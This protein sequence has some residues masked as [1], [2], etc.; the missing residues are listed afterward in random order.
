VTEPVSLIRRLRKA[1][2]TIR[3][4]GSRLIVE[5]PAGI[6][7]SELHALLIQQKP[8]LLTT[9]ANE[10]DDGVNGDGEV[11]RD[12]AV[13]DI[14]GLLATAYRRYLTLRTLRGEKRIGDARLANSGSPSVHGVVS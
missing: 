2:V 1:G 12:Q 14:M 4:E 9:L 7:T 11:A 10:A 6:I 8:E 5:A 13:R 3:A